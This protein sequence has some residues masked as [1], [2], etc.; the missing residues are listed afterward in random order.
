MHRMLKIEWDAV[1]GVLAAVIAIVLHLLHVIEAEVLSVITL[2]LLAAMFLRSLRSD[3]GQAA[4]RSRRGPRRASA[5]PAGPERQP[6]GCDGRRPPGSAAGERGVLAQREGGH[7]LVQRLPVDVRAPAALRRAA[8]TGH[9]EPGGDRRTRSHGQGL[10]RGR[11]LAAARRRGRRDPHRGVGRARSAAI[12]ATGH[13]GRSAERVEVG[14]V[15]RAG[16]ADVEARTGPV[17]LLAAVPPA[18]P[19]PRAPPC[20]TDQVITGASHPEQVGGGFHDQQRS[21]AARPC[22]TR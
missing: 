12:R 8:A 10:C 3:H 6:P 22:S 19:L 11:T 7:G 18:G 4:H 15:V 17:V 2:V 21:T 16:V 5:G 1:A 9:R 13:Q 20:T 14:A